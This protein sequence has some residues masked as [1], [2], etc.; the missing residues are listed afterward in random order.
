MGP[1]DSLTGMGEA[2]AILGV[3][4]E[5]GRPRKDECVYIPHC[6][7]IPMLDQQVVVDRKQ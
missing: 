5:W 1:G 6:V 7:G 2:L 4:R 3:G